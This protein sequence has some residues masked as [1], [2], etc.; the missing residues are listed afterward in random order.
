MLLKQLIFLYLISNFS[1]VYGKCFS[2]YDN[3]PK[4]L[5]FTNCTIYN[6]LCIPSNNKN[7]DILHFLVHGLTYDNHYWDWN[8]D[9]SYTLYANKKG[10]STLAIDRFGSG[11]SSKYE[12]G[13]NITLDTHV[14]Y[15]HYIINKYKRKYGF[16]KIVYVG[17]SLGSMIGVAL[18]NKYEK[19]V[20]SLVLTG[21]SHYINTTLFG[22]ISNYV[23]YFDNN[24][25][26]TID[27]N[28]R[29]ELF[30]YGNYSLDILL[31]D[32]E[33]KQNA[34]IGEVNTVG[35]GLNKS[36]AE[37]PIYIIGG[38]NDLIFNNKIEN[39]SNYN[40]S[41]ITIKTIPNTGHCINLH[42]NSNIFYNYILNWI[43]KN[44]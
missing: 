44:N 41:K 4:S 39:I 20:N 35:I 37:I 15:I 11:L 29:E 34:T 28:I 7:K 2:N 31:E 5:G 24:Y 21:Y 12:N 9:T 17:H 3:I 25:F 19:D 26:T 36:Y 13:Y 43:K 33:N 30:Y 14:N 10:Y 8:N 16:K 32:E 42:N 40:S 18:T 22:D 23:K 27:K 1:K 6:K 38:E